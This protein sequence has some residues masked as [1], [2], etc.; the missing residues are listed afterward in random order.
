MLSRIVLCMLLVDS[1]VRSSYNT[2]F[3]Q[4]VIN[5]VTFLK[6]CSFVRS[7]HHSHHCLS[8]ILYFR[9]IPY[10]GLCLSRMHADWQKMHPAV[11]ETILFMLHIIH[12]MQ[13]N[14]EPKTS[15]VPCLPFAASSKNK[16]SN[17]LVFFSSYN[18]IP[19]PVWRLFSGR[20]LIGLWDIRLQTSKETMTFGA[21]E[22]EVDN[23]FKN[24]II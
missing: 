11:K 9:W 16:K 23:T 22:F 10:V 2:E 21:S 6:G 5:I 15:R 8:I 18:W 3:T 13:K 7:F 12:N 4:A 17:F 1:D 20:C 14:F 24:V 19:F